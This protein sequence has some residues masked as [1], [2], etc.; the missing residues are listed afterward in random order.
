VIRT[1]ALL[2]WVA[3]IVLDPHAALHLL[4]VAGGYVLHL[5]KVWWAR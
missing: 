2:A 3:L 4:T 5:V 1:V